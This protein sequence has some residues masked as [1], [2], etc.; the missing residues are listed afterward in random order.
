[1]NIKTRTHLKANDEKQIKSINLSLKNALF[2]E[3]SIYLKRILLITVYH[4]LIKV[5]LFI[6][7]ILYHINTYLSTLIL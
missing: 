4:K 3:M 1:M 2:K 5:N 7:S 6:R